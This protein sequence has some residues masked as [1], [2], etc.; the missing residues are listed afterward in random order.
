MRFLHI[1][2][3]AGALVCGCQ[4]PP[5]TNP[6]LA[7][8]VSQVFEQP[9]WFTYF[10]DDGSFSLSFPKAPERVGKDPKSQLLACPL[11]KQ[12]SNLSLIQMTLPEGLSAQ[13][14]SKDPE[15]FFGQAVQLVS[16][17]E[18]QI[19]GREALS[20]E[21]LAGPNRV[22]VTMVFARPYLYQLIALQSPASPQDY[23]GERQ[24]FFA[25][26]HF[27]QTR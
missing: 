6:N 11:D 24:N 8:P 3:L 18:S 5:A 20:V 14:L 21:M 26:F 23:A 15:K 17:K 7:P 4:A 22:W 1:W 12:G 10:A 2:A 27:T 16:V 9:G 25:S 19:E 13:S